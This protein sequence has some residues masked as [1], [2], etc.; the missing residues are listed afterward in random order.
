MPL[1]FGPHRMFTKVTCIDIRLLGV[2]TTNGVGFPG[3]Q[4]LIVEEHD[5]TLLERPLSILPK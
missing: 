3:P 5:L 4:E 2:A 1:A